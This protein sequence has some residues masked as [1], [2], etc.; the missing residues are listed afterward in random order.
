MPAAMSSSPAPSGNSGALSTI[1]STPNGS[2]S[3][4][5][6]PSFDLPKQSLRGI[7][8][9]KCMQCGNIARSRCP[10]Q[11]CKSCCF[12]AQN[13]CHIH[14]LKANGTLPEKAQPASS[15]TPEQP[16]TDSSSFASGAAMRLSSL[17]KF[18]S[19]VV[20]SL[21]TRRPLSRKDAMNI[22]KWRFSKLKEHNDREIEV[23]DEAFDRYMKNVTL[24]EETFSAGA[25]ED[26]TSLAPETCS[27][28]DR[29]KKLVT[30]M[31]TRLESNDETANAF[32]DELREVVGKG[33][34]T[35]KQFEE[36]AEVDGDNVRD[37]SAEFKRQRKL[38]KAR[39]QRTAAVED[40]IDKMIKARTEDDLKSC[41]EAKL[42]MY[43]QDS[44]D[45]AASKEEPRR[46]SII[47]VDEDHL[48]NVDKEFSS[49]GQ[50]VEL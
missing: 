16:I 31:K 22:N 47:K 36:A 8:K 23:E 39:F 13:P 38:M 49:V 2:I 27:S 7:K 45:D 40:L 28:K 19:A 33:L 37:S 35:L 5:R 30:G 20:S 12:K 44:D 24:L 11:S 6:S 1:T 48:S 29:F 26:E 43:N 21:R 25:I 9:P 3:S 15:P 14:V 17:R 10:F 34:R 50:L 42:Q 18:S 32:R 46:L 4:Q 41:L